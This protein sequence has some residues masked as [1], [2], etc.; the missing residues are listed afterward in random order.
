M[1]IIKTTIATAAVITCCLGNEMPAKALDKSSFDAG[2]AYGY[3]YSV[4]VTA[5]MNYR[6][7]DITRSKMLTQMRA[8]QDLDVWTPAINSAILGNFEEA[9]LEG[10]KVGPCLPA[11]RQVFGIGTLY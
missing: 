1:N 2:Y 7:G 8:T 9:A 6:L 11:V 4:A 5:C 3:M 10:K